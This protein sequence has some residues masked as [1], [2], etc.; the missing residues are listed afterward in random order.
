MGVRGGGGQEEGLAGPE[1]VGWGRRRSYPTPLPS[2]LPTRA[3][4]PRSLAV[5][6]EHDCQRH[7]TGKKASSCSVG[8]LSG[9]KYQ[10][11]CSGFV[12]GE[13][14]GGCEGELPGRS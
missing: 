5:W 1:T 11:F 3:A 9:V 10:V 8:R 2:S 13:F 7:F 12:F 6:G 4:E 14:F